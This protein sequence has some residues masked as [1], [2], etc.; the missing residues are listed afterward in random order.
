[1]AN[2][3]SNGGSHFQSLSCFYFQ[4]ILMRSGKEFLR[5]GQVVLPEQQNLCPYLFIFNWRI[6]ALH[7]VLVSAVQ[8]CESAISIHMPPPF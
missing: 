5:P 3:R 8:Q 4:D 6:I 2:S 7:V 1:M